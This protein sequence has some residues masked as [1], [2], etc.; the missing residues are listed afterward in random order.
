MCV[1]HFSVFISCMAKWMW[2][3]VLINA[4][5]IHSKIHLK[6]SLSKDNKKEAKKE[7]KNKAKIVIANNNRQRDD[8]I[9]VSVR[10]RWEAHE[11]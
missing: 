11:K 5:D 7:E 10:S 8:E 2:P 6:K 4:L 9:V 3:F 1:V